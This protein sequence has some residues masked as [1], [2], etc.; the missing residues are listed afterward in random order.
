MNSRA[1][2][3]F[4]ELF[5]NRLVGA[6]NGL[7][8][9]SCRKEGEE[10]DVP[11]SS[12]N[13]KLA[14]DVS[15]ALTANHSVWSRA[16]LSKISFDAKNRH[17]LMKILKPKKFQAIMAQATRYQLKQA[18][19]LNKR[20]SNGLSGSRQSLA[21]YKSFCSK[22]LEPGSSSNTRLLHRRTRELQNLVPGGKSMKISCLLGETADYIDS[23]TT[24]VQVLQ[25]LLNSV[26]N[27]QHP[28]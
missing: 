23:L 5:L 2:S 9:P 14:A 4:R 3:N 10:A 20:T 28:L 6:L 26:N 8:K 22:R 18:H 7:Q 24:Q 19:V 21:L 1:D 13:I 16:L 15:L 12:H 11:G 25:S 17:V 27:N